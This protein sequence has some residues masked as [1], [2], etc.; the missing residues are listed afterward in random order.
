MVNEVLK[1]VILMEMIVIWVMNEVLMMVLLM[2]MIV[3]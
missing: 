1:M 3:I 2:D